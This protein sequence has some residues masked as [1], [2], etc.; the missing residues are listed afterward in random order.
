MAEIK[1]EQYLARIRP[2]YDNDMV[3]VL[4]GIRRSGK[5]TLLR[6]IIEELKNNIPERQII[7]INFEDYA[8]HS[9]CTA[10]ALYHFI[11]PMLVTKEKYYLFFDEIQNVENFELVINSLRSVQNT[12]IFITGSN[13]K[14]LSGDLATHLS[15]RTLLFRI[16]PFSFK[17]FC[18]FKGTKNNEALFS[19]YLRWGG[20]PQ[21]CAQESNENKSFVLSAIYNDVVL[22]D[23]ITRNKIA[24]PNAIMRIFVY[25]IGNSSLTLSVKDIEKELASSNLGI[26]I[27]S[28][29]DYIRYGEE[30]C[31]FDKVSRFDI[32]G[33][34]VLRFE[35]KVYASDL[36]LISMEKNRVKDE[37][38]TYCE[39]IVYNELISRGYLVNIGKTYKG[40]V[41]FIA[42]KGDEK[43]YYQVTYMMSDAAAADREFGA[44]KGIA[45][46]YPKYVLSLDPLPLSRDGIIHK[47]LI[48]WLLGEE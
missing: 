9:L 7:Y 37:Y 26:S 40:E 8:Y 18:A 10:D 42:T 23:V 19:E 45:D 41:D 5:S 39:T 6:Q 27:P 29:Y 44:F 43:N 34:A 30:A 25:L 2:F 4:M 33:K 15:G 20:F 28:I 24:S 22:R 3:K 32:R 1:R 21:V 13:S 12:S 31:L 36:G 38:N 17:E 16:Q 46:N 11:I 48:N 14:L 47:N 35:E